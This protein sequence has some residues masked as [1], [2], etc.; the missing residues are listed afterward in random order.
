MHDLAK[1]ETITNIRPIEGKDRIV[2]ATVAN[3]NTIIEKDSFKEGDKC[4]Y[5]YYDSIL[6]LM[7]PATK[8]PDF[9][10]LRKRCYS[11]KYKGFRIRPMKMGGVVSE[12]LVL[13]LSVLPGSEKLSVGTN[14]TNKLGITLYNPEEVIEIKSRKYSKLRT[15]LCRYKVFRK[16][17]M[18]IDKLTGRA[19]VK[20][21][22][23]N[24]IIKSDEENIEACYDEISKY[25]DTEYIIS[26]KIEGQAT[27]L[28]IEKNKLVVYSHNY[29]VNFG[30]WY[31]YATTNS[32][33]AKLKRVCEEFNEKELAIQGELIGPGIQKNIYGRS[34]FELYLYG[35]FHKDNKRFT[36]E[37]VKKV[38]EITGIPT[39]PYIRTDIIKPLDDMLKD[40][41]GKSVLENPMTKKP[42]EREGLVYRTE[43]GYM[44]FKCKSRNY[45]IWYENG[46]KD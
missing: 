21:G 18:F 44:H 20:A 33:E 1:I 14:V 24:W 30:N 40:C 31:E 8:K 35:G 41:E 38:S 15:A 2:L 13:P 45:K 39:V 10:F 36:W 26:E 43:D 25:P 19:R 46:N 11:D 42:V 9:E 28:S 37:E 29:R 32:I 12:G 5:C 4:I 22:Y 3:Y 27:T 34:N 6:P 17:F 7:N 23:P 16:F